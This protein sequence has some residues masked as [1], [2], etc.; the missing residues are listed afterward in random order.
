MNDRSKFRIWDKEEKK[1][2]LPSSS[3]GNFTENI[4]QTLDGTLLLLQ[5]DHINDTAKVRQYYPGRLIRMDCTGLKDKNGK[6]IY[7]GDTVKN[8]SGNVG[9]VLWWCGA[10]MMAP[11]PKEGEQPIIL[12]QEPI[13]EIVGNKFENPELLKQ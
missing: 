10:W 12:W 6:L 11:I 2:I 5:E 1:M 8:Q 4:V 3:E 7:E 9:E 13:L